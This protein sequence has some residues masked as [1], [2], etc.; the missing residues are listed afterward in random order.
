MSS[1]TG[2]TIRYGLFGLTA[3]TFI[4]ALFLNLFLPGWAAQGIIVAGIHGFIGV[5]M[6]IYYPPAI[7]FSLKDSRNRWDQGG[8]EVAVQVLLAV[9]W[10]AAFIWQIIIASARLC[11][12][13]DS[14]FYVNDPKCQPAAI[15]L[16]VLYFINLVIHT[17]WAAWIITIV[18]KNSTGRR[19]RDDVYEIPSHDLVR[20]RTTRHVDTTK[21]TGDEEAGLY[22]LRT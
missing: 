10:L 12:D 7:Y 2:P 19:E 1:T 9:A 4:L 21:I 13:P 3:V 20:G 11:D 18:E 8:G 17:G 14:G 5:V 16:T 22:N 6:L 15:G